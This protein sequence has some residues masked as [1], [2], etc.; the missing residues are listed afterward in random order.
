MVSEPQMFYFRGHRLLEILILIFYF[1]IY[2]LLTY[3]SFMESLYNWNPS[4]SFCRIY[5]WFFVVVSFM[6][7]FFP[8]ISR[9]NCVKVIVLNFVDHINSNGFFYPWTEGRLFIKPYMERILDHEHPTLFP[10][11]IFKLF[12][13]NY[14]SN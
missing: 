11:E 9:M 12:I 2:M 7:D 6:K 13:S 3:F 1:Y 4:F 10:D 8:L 5:D 14:F